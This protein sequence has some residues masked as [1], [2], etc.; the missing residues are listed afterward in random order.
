MKFSIESIDYFNSIGLDTKKIKALQTTIN[1]FLNS[2]IP[3]I[4]NEPVMVFSDVHANITGL[5]MAMDFS[6]GN[7]I[8][9]FI[10]LGDLIEYNLHNNEVLQKITNYKDDFISLIKGNH[11]NGMFSD[12]G[13]YITSYFKDKIHGKFGLFIDDLDRFDVIQIQD[14]K[15]L[16]CHSNPW[17]YDTAYLFPNDIEHFE[18]FYNF[19]NCDGF[20]YGH[21][22]I[23]DFQISKNRKNFAFN[24]GSL[25]V[26]RYGKP[27]LTF[28]WLYPDG[29][30][31]IYEI[32]HKK[33][34]FT[35][36][37]DKEPNLIKS[38]QIP[39]Q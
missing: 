13:E 8:D 11:D 9:K 10:S 39:I 35:T 5:N 12:S 24:P 23:L 33:Y 27:R 2:R 3:K 32:K 7:S 29:K 4:L 14:R 31:E 25:G 38:F 6:K 20:L 26:S 19:L 16:L 21:T 22:H 28:S 30:I 17:G 36:L 37:L 1:N 18:Y 15:I 34:E